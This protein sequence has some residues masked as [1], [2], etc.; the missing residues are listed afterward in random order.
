[1]SLLKPAQHLEV[2][3]HKSISAEFIYSITLR[4]TQKYWLSLRQN[5]LYTRSELKTP[6]S[7]TSCLALG[8]DIKLSDDDTECNHF[9]LLSK[10]T[11]CVSFPLR[12]AGRQEDRER[13]RESGIRQQW[14]SRSS[15]QRPK[16]G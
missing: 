10:H 11:D 12:H 15:I 1:M 6:L 9:T 16:S 13:E 8:F 7:G 3:Y 4:I 14:A 2:Q 5:R